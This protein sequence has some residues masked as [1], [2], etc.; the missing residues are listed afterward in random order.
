MSLLVD[1]WIPEGTCSQVLRSTLVDSQRFESIRIFCIKIDWNCNFCGFI[2]PSPF[3]FSLFLALLGYQFPNF[4]TNFFWRRITDECS[5]PE[6]HIWSIL[7]IKSDLIYILVEVSFYILTT[8]WLCH[9]WWTSESSRAH[10][11]MFYGRLRLIRSVLRASK[12]SASKLIEIVILWV[13]Y[14]TPLA[15]DCF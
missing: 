14:T 13:H 9:C 8:L 11:A 2:T 3:G 10:E 15:S 5:V 1:Q 4:E 12:F 6:M 7:W